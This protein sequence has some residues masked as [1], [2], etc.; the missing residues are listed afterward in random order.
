MY[1]DIEQHTGLIYEG[2]GRLV[3]W[4]PHC[5]HYRT[6]QRDSLADRLP[7]LST[8]GQGLSAVAQPLRT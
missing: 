6:D 7:L 4:S 5:G 8:P 3:H 1:L 2:T